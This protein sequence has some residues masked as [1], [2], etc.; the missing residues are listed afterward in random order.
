MFIF[1]ACPK[2]T[3]QK[4]GH[5]Y[6]VFLLHKTT[7]KIL[8]SFQGFRNSLRILFVILRKRMQSFALL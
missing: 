8:N 5:F 3:N 4:K 6:E 1:F 7:N 2:K